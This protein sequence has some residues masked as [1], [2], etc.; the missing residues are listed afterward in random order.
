MRRVCIVTAGRLSTCPRMLK[1]ADACHQAG[2]AVRVIS[3]RTN[4][5]STAADTAIAASRQWTWRFV[6]YDRSEA[7][8][9]W[10]RSGARHKA[11]RAF[12]NLLTSVP[13]SVATLAFA[14][15]HRELV[16]AIL[17][18][19]ADFVYGGTTGAIAAVAEAARRSGTPF[20]VDFEDFHC[21]EHEASPEGTL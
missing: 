9:T 10:L 5:W 1:A 11:A 4:G 21:A 3:T 14:R 15:V 13:A 17:D 19:P 8:T 2:Y 6:N 7:T 20:A 16:D 18:A 12:A